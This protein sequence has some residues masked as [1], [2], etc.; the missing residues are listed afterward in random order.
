M[1]AKESAGQASHSHVPPAQKAA[2][3]S[4]ALA[5]KYNAAILVEKALGRL[6]AERGA[7]SSGKSQRTSAPK[8]AP[9]GMSKKWCW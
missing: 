9:V 7:C 3:K 5:T 2:L 1:H 4:A 6:L 8:A